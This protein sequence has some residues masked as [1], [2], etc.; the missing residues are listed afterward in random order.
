MYDPERHKHI[1]KLTNSDPL[2]ADGIYRC[3]YL[4]M[5]GY[6]EQ[7]IAV[8]QENHRHAQCRE[9]PFD[10]A[11]ALTLGAQVFDFCNNPEQLLIHAREGEELGR[12][13]GLPLMSEVLAEISKGI[14]SLRMRHTDSVTKMRQVTTRLAETGQLIWGPYLTALLAEAICRDGDPDKALEVISKAIADSNLRQE[15]SH[16]AEILRLE[17]WMLLEAGKNDEAEQ[18][19]ENSIAFARQQQSRSWELRS[20]MTLVGLLNN[21]GQKREARERLENIYNWFT[22]GHNTHDLVQARLLLDKLDR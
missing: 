5:L 11:F 18:V 9:H 1:V 12:A 19:I 14:V 21:R 13:H 16:Y 17:G 7:A 4:W 3:Q 6:P 22:E 20:T 10:H 15:F 8:C 2:T